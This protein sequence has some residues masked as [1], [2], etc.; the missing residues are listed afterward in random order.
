MQ[1]NSKPDRIAV[2]PADACQMLGLS[3]A[4]VFRML[5]SG[6]LAKAKIGRR[7]LIRVADLNNLLTSA[8]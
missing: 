8:S 1:D 3:R 7:T 6:V 2:S 4:T 5:Q